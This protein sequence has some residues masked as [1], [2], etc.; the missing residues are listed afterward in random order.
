MVHEH[1]RLLNH[2]DGA[3]FPKNLLHFSDLTRLTKSAFP[4][5]EF[6]HFM[7]IFGF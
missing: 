3:S 6:F 4:A 2:S 7:N 1:A 5:S